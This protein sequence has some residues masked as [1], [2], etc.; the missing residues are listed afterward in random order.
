MTPWFLGLDVGGTHT[1][2]VL[3]DAA[4]RVRGI[5]QAASANPHNVG[6][7]TARVRLHEAASSAWTSAGKV[8]QPARHAF[9][10]CAGVKSRREILE[11]RA[12][13]EGEGFAAAGDVTVENDLHNALAGG[14]G[15]RSGIALIAGTGSN[16][17]G[18]D[19]RGKTFLC[20]GWGWL[21]DDEGSG[22]GLA[23][24][25]MRAV[26]R[27]ADGR[28]RPTSLTA[29]VLAFFGIAEPDELLACLY[30]R[31]WTPGEVADFAPVVM[32]HAAEGDAVAKGIL[33]AGA[34]ALAGLVAGAV[35]ALEFPRGADV[36]ILGGCGRSGPPYQELVERELS[37]ACPGIRL[38]E[39]E[40][41]PLAGA[42]LN[43]LQFGGIRPLP[44]L[45]KPL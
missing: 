39:P 3:V 25:A 5:G 16:C 40:G 36:V 27:A 12:L 29:A 38:L 20:G 23:M 45:S 24:A 14:L 35:R 1:R 30:V 41:S 44:T 43:A 31:R 7:R 28:A 4:G 6:I 26:A 22:F 19:A 18:R 10:G 37:A 13:A 2:A 33:L 11:M 34:R 15:G 8:F 32:R 9:L 42:A 21:L 17:L